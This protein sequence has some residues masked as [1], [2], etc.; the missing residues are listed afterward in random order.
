MGLAIAIRNS[1]I[2]LTN[3]DLRYL[4]MTQIAL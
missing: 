4:I 2:Y 3:M 1:Y